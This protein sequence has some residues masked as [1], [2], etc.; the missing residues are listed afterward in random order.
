[1]YEEPGGKI[2][3]VGLFNRITASQ[4]PAKHPRM[5][6][7]VSLTGVREGVTGRLD[8]VHGET[9][10]PIA[11]ASGGFPKA[12]GP[13]SVVDMTFVLNE[14]VFPEPGTYYIRFFGNEYP[15]VMR[16]FEVSKAPGSGSS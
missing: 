14:L 10:E 9:D 16:P 2:A 15:L 1:V 8:I 7:Y 13:T 4:F 11:G 5:V 3:L 6:I 12:I